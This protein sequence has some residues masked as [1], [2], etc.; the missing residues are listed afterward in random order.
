MELKCGL[1]WRKPHP[2]LCYCRQMSR[3]ILN[4][5]STTWGA[6]ASPDIGVHFLIMVALKATASRKRL[7]V[8]NK[9][10]PSL[11]T[12]YSTFIL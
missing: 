2:Y 10:N 11:A 9:K 5:I 12:I 4:L 7:L 1:Y 8:Q 3:Q 6:P